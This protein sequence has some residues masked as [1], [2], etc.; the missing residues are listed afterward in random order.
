MSLIEKAL[1]KL[2]GP[3]QGSSGA[4]TRMQ[5]PSLR[6]PDPRSSGE[7]QWRITDA[8]RERLGLTVDDLANQRASEYRHIKRQIVSEIAANPQH[9]IVLVVSALSGEGKS[10]TSAN[11]ARS[12]AREQDYTVL[13][14]D[15][16]VVKPQLTRELGLM[17][18]PG[19]MNALVDASCDVDSLILTTDIDGLSVLPAG[20]ASENATEHFSSER[21]RTVLNRLQAVP[22][23]IVL[24]DALPLL[25]TTEARALLPLAS[26]VLLV[27]RSE[28][29]PQA[30]IQ[31]ALGLVGEDIN[32]KLVLNAVV[33]TR[34][35]KYLGYGYDFDYSYP[36][37][38]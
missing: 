10:F 37:K 22:N 27:V 17:D 3:A 26:Q 14:V 29:T 32:V 11:L 28:S 31:Q 7:P 9:R 4:T 19:L 30:A 34:I 24:I 33:R 2:K 5:R 13:L 35:T 16:D 6:M 1:G 12:L 21:M 25:L 15:A 23:R 18:R 36:P 8:M 38:R 20:S